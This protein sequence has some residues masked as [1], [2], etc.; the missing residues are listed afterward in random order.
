MTFI[1]EIQSIKRPFYGDL[2]MY[3]TE[4]VWQKKEI[5]I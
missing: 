1:L 5:W 4:S 3:T 2:L